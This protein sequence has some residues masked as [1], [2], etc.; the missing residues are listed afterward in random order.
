[1][2]TYWDTL[3]LRERWMLGVGGV[4]CFFVLLYWLIL[5]PLSNAVQ[6][7]SRQLIEKRDTLVWM[8]QVR[9]QRETAK[10]PLSLTSSKLLSVLAAQLKSTSFRRF[11]YQLQQ[12]GSGDIQLTFDRVPYNALVTWLW[13]VNKRYAFTIKQFTAER[14]DTSGVV[15]AMVVITV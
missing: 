2:K 5:A 13:S 14:T 3:N 10:A 15:N 1:M 12:T 6:D 8:Q 7:K 9:H 4:F 11:P